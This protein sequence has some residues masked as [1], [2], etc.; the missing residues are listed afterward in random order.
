MVS[1]LCN[2]QK[3]SNKNIV[4][5]RIE[6][7]RLIK[8]G[9]TYQNKNLDST[10][11]FYHKALQININPK[12]TLLARLYYKIGSAYLLEGNY[13][14][15][16]EYQLNALRIYED[17]PNNKD[18]VKV[19]NSIALI[20]FYVKDYDKALDYFNKAIDLLNKNFDGDNLKIN[21]YLG[22]VYNNIGIIYD[23]KN[24]LSLAIEFYSK[25][26]SFS[27]KINDSENLSTVYS[28]MGIVY[29][30]ENKYDLAE[31][32]FNEAYKIRLKQNNIYGLSKSFYHLGR[33]NNEKGNFN[34]ALDFLS[35][36]VDFSI[37]SNASST[38]MN[39]YDEL[40]KV[41]SSK[42][43][44]ELAFK[45][46]KLFHRLKDSLDNKESH[47]K[48]IEANLLYAFEKESKAIKK[49]NKQREFIY[50]GA[51]IL[52][53]LL[54]FSII[55]RYKLQKS[56]AKLHLFDKEFIQLSHQEAV[57]R[58]EN[59]KKELEFKNKELTTNI[60]YLVKKNE[61]ITDISEKLKKLK[62]DTNK[63]NQTI[64][65]KIIFDL[66]QAEDHS[67]WKEFEVR[68]NQVYNDFYDRLNGKYPDLTINEKRI[69]AFL[70]LNMTSKEICTL[71]RQ[72]YN[73]LTVARSRLRK[74]LNIQNEEISL[75]NFLQNL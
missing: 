10:L 70:R 30:K 58:E 47:Q 50:W 26:L 6:I 27:K 43:N 25:A 71:T 5:N 11:Y 52:L 45:N 67:L 20:Y 73:S 24:N 13:S 41:Y 55:N 9:N 35:K 60:I 28:N 34:K 32:M 8:K 38:R 49:L 21:K 33:L 72:S 14:K 3:V 17:Y 62:K 23:N 64:I 75:S 18:I 59:L 46:L 22:N 4:D 54:L 15:S 42:K 74:K 39:A 69:C 51:L 37:K 66:K 12:D 1:S 63:E 48:T 29:L 57:L 40:S 2:A 61:L 65:N 68:F 56:K 44:Y 16:Q 36:A 31:A 7:S 53:I 19:Y